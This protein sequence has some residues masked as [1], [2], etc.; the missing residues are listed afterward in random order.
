MSLDIHRCRFLDYNPS[1]ITS[2]SFTTDSSTKTTASD[3]RLAV[4]R[5][6]GNIEIWNP[7]HNW[8]HEIVSSITNHI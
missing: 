1:A 8:I 3:V 5:G 6:N 2:L 7:R 4:G